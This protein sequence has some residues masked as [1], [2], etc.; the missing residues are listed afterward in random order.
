MGAPG[1]RSKVPP[2][3]RD[4]RI[5]SVAEVRF[6][7]GSGT[8][9][10]NLNLNR[11]TFVELNIEPQPNPVNR[12]WKQAGR[13]YTVSD[14]VFD[15]HA[16]TTDLGDQQLDE[17]PFSMRRLCKAFDGPSGIVKRR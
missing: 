14:A 13:G 1:F 3:S 16:M 11:K 8:F 9:A 4:T 7:F 15:V 6:R 5:F 17:R 10:Q 12:R 2:A